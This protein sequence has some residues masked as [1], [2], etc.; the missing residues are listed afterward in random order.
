MLSVHRKTQGKVAGNRGN[1][2]K[3]I[4]NRRKPL[5][6]PLVFEEVLSENTIFGHTPGSIYI[7][8]LKVGSPPP[9][10]GA[11]GSPTT[12][13]ARSARILGGRG[14]PRRPV[15]PPDGGLRPRRST[16]SVDRSLGR[17]V[18][19]SLGR[20]ASR[21]VQSL[22]RSWSALCPEFRHESSCSDEGP[23]GRAAEKPRDVASW[24]ELPASPAN[25]RLLPFPPALASSP[26]RARPSPEI[27]FKETIRTCLNQ[28]GARVS[29]NWA[30]AI[31]HSPR[32]LLTFKGN[33][34]T[35]SPRQS[36]RL[37]TLHPAGSAQDSPVQP[38]R[39]MLA[40]CVKLVKL[41][42]NWCKTGWENIQNW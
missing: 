37:P 18:A 35:I 40:L 21:A 14:R 38:S 16:W 5:R 29:L 19:R 11:C 7:T 42:Y 25:P 8:K 10:S 2:R 22:D 1:L 41:V 3:P 39:A 27:K 32:P 4:G 13:P 23:P 9:R 12:K 34:G 20:S 36:S 31:F 6:K 26:L 15:V 24:P 33:E 17:S 30:R 28:T